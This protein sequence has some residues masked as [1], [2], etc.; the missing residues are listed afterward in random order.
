MLNVMSQ[1]VG[2]LI[3]RERPFSRVVYWFE[4]RGS[5]SLTRFG[6]QAVSESRVGWG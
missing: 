3:W 6:E 5:V 4:L 2:G 1:A